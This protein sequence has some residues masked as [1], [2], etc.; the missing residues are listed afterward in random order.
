VEMVGRDLVFRDQTAAPT[1]KISRL[2][3]AGQ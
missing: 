2:T 1:V 3:V